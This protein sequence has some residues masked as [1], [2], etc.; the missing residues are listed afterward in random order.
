MLMPTCLNKHELDRIYAGS[1]S[2]CGLFV[3]SSSSS[4]SK[5]KAIEEFGL[6]DCL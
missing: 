1:F 4:V 3:N 6:A 5:S 2:P